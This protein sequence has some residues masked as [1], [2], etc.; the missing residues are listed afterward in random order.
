VTSGAAAGRY[1]RALF[2]VVIAESPATL[3]AAQS[4]LQS[5]C[6]LFAGNEALAGVTANPSIP[7]ARK[8]ALA[9]ALVERAGA[10]TPAAGKLIVLLASRDRL[11]LLPEVAR[12]FRARLMDHQKVIRGDVTTA[13]PLPPEKLRALEQ[14]LQRATGRT[15]QLESRVDPSIIGG[16]ITRLG[17]TVYDGSVTTQLDKMKQALIEAGH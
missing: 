17:S 11:M 15:V 8:T 6:E 4:D 9:K 7:V 16:V 10:V 13:T 5:F 12:A 14:G 2:D 3:D 1:A